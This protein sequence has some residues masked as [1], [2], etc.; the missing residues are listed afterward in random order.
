[1][2][3]YLMIKNAIISLLLTV[4]YLRWLVEGI[5]PIKIV[6]GCVAIFVSLMYLLCMAD[7]CYIKAIKK[8]APAEA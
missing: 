2:R 8:S 1:M 7:D 4:M 6:V 5:H 3:K